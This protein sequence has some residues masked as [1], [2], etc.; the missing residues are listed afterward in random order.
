ML[1][2][3]KRG[4]TLGRIEMA[5]ELDIKALRYFVAVAE[6]GSFSQAATHLRI[7]QPAVSRQIQAIEKAYGIRLFRTEGRR[8]LLT[9]AGEQLLQQATEVLGKLDDIGVS[10]QSA[11]LE[12]AGRITLGVTT[13][14]AEILMPDVLMRYRSR[15]PNVFVHIVQGTSSELRELMTDGALDLALIYGQPAKA[16]PS[17]LPL[18]DLHIG[19]VAPPAN[20]LRGKDPV[21][22]KPAI[23]LAEAATLPLIFPGPR[24]AQRQALEQALGKAQLTPNIVLES[25]SLLLSKALVKRGLG[26]MLIAYVGVHEEVQQGKLRFVT[27]ETPDIVWRMFL[28]SR[29]NKQPS[30]A[31]R[32]MANEIMEAIRHGGQDNRWRGDVLV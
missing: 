7:T 25:E 31:V 5:F 16:T 32:A 17:M 13:S 24:D 3:Q 4:D 1:S 10:M 23:S 18:L 8:M 12:P 9:E 27:L 30:L 20:A 2:V 21:Q 26:Y 28:V 19:L 14:P 11:A 22:G 29:S 6:R 15:H